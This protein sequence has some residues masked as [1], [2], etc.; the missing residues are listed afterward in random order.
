MLIARCTRNFSENILF[1][2]LWH[3]LNQ[4]CPV[5]CCQVDPIPC[6]LESTEG[7]IPMFNGISWS[8]SMAMSL[9]PVRNLVNKSR[10]YSSIKKQ[11][12]SVFSLKSYEIVDYFNFTYRTNIVDLF[13]F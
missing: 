8:A 4:E 11:E 7:S 12:F 1:V 3:V 13:L 10:C 2:Y 5:V 6:N 9:D